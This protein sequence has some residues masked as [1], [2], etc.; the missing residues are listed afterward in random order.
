MCRMQHEYHAADEWIS[1]YILKKNFGRFYEIDYFVIYGSAYTNMPF[2]HHV[3]TKRPNLTVAFHF[4][5]LS[6]EGLKFR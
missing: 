4:D 5:E 1:Y 6:Y 3:C 2:L